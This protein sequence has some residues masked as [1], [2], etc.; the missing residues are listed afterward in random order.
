MHYNRLDVDR[1]LAETFV[2]RVEYYQTLGSTNDRARQCAGAGP[3]ELPLLV[4]ADMQTAGRGRGTNLWWTGRGS[5][6]FSLLLGADELGEAERNRSP[7]VSLA[8]AVAVVEAVGPLLPSIPVGIRWP[9]DVV[10]GGGKLA[11]ILVEGLPEGRL[12]VGIGVNTN[13]SLAEAPPELRRTATTLLEL[14]GVRHEQTGI[15]VALLGCLEKAFGQLASQP[16]R[17]GAEAD[18]LCLWRGKTLN[19]LVG[20][21]AITGRCDGI[22]PDGALILDT[23]QGRQ[24]LYSGVVR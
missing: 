12:V 6:A 7:L 20:D 4:V 22:A 11:G 21:Q 23:P 24:T 3:G 2:A 8:A 15:L 16:D 5:L 17:I 1:L 10:A 13:C 14:T 9:N 18:A 19:L